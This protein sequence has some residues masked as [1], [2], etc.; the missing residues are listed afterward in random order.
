MPDDTTSDRKPDGRRERWRAHREARRRELVRGVVAVV[1]HRG[2]V[3][4]DDIATETGIAKQVYYRY[5][6]DKADLHRA[7]GIAA[8]RAVVREV[9]A[10][11]EAE[12]DPREQLR[13]GI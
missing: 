10:C 4:M 2:A 6:S 11:I 8:A 13:A 7:V 3:G 5:F 1:R 9:A 12:S